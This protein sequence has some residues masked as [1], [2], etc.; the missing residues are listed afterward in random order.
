MRKEKHETLKQRYEQG[1]QEKK[2]EK[3]KMEKN[4]REYA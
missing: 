4:E 3:E 2:Q 1:R